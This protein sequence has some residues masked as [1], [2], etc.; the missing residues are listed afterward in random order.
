MS[1]SARLPTA[2]LLA[3]VALPPFLSAALLVHGAAVGLLVLVLT[4]EQANSGSGQR[5]GREV[6]VLW[7]RLAPAV[8]MLGGALAW[9]RMPKVLLGLGSLGC[10]PGL[11]R[12]AAIVP[13]FVAALLVLAVPAQG[14]PSAWLRGEGGWFHLGRAIPDA[15][16]GV[17]GAAEG[18]WAWPVAGACLLG[19]VL[20]ARAWGAGALG[21]VVVGSLLADGFFDGG[22]LGVMVVAHVV[23]WVALPKW[24]A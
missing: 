22:G 14:A 5:L 3:R 4:V 1:L 15:V 11:V 9:A 8:S 21:V 10:G 19:A 24:A 13:G 7:A 6:I 20:G 17:V 18:V 12:W 23:L 2:A 16:G